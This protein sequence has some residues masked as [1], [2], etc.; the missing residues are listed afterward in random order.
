M[1]DVEGFTKQTITRLFNQR[2]LYFVMLVTKDEN[3]DYKKPEVIGEY[4]ENISQDMF[5]STIK[6]ADRMH[7]MDETSR[8]NFC[9]LFS[10]LTPP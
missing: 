1:E 5:A 3:K 10:I 7:N 2:V 4:L 9:V 6:T 8:E